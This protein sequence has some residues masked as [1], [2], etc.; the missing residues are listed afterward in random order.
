MPAERHAPP[1]SSC[2][3]PG[4]PIGPN[5]DRI[6]PT[7]RRSVHWCGR[8]SAR[9][10]AAQ[11]ASGDRPFGHRRQSYAAGRAVLRAA[12]PPG[13]SSCAASVRR[14][15]RPRGCG[16]SVPSRSR[17]GTPAR[18]PAIRGA[19][20]HRRR[21]L[22]SCARPQA[23]PARRFRQWAARQFRKTDSIRAAAA[24]RRHGAQPRCVPACRTT[25]GPPRRM[26]FPRPASRAISAL[27]AV[28]K[29][30]HR[31]PAAAS[32]PGTS[33]APP[34]AKLRETCRG[35]AAF[36]SPETGT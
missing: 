15:G 32:H 30:Q 2:A 4:S 22:R 14:V 6:L 21:G 7:W 12:P 28:R 23:I 1:S 19:P 13:S 18:I 34:S 17:S 5:P 29:D 25:P 11:A 31:S 16:C 8:M 9:A 33:R 20:D 10:I 35:K 24:R 26:S 3:R 36:P 27:G